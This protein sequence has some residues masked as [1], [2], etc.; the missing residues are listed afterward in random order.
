[1]ITDHYGVEIMPGSKV[2]FNYSGE[3]RLGEVVSVGPPVAKNPYWTR[4]AIRIRHQGDRKTISVIASRR[5]L[6]VLEQ[7]E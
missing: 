6:V 2:A 4:D 3:V 5:N 1:M 7:P